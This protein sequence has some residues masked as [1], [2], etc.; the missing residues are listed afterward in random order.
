MEILPV[1]TIGLNDIREDN[2]VFQ[3]SG[4]MAYGSNLKLCSGLL[5]VKNK[6]PAQLW[7]LS[8]HIYDNPIEFGE[9]KF[10]MPLTYVNDLLN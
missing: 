7:E 10:E 6:K 3:L 4:N 9:I 8:I 5:T 1:S 2:M